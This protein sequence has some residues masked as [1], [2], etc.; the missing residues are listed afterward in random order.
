MT[1][2]DADDVGTILLVEQVVH[3]PYLGVTTPLVG[4]VYWERWSAVPDPHARIAA[5]ASD[6]GILTLW[7]GWCFVSVVIYIRRG[8]RA[9]KG[10]C[11]IAWRLFLGLT[12]KPQWSVTVRQL[13]ASLT[14]KLAHLIVCDLGDCCCQTG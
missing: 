14:Q 11:R 6:I 12:E 7:R 5:S 3:Y 13:D 8:G 2:L 4:E 10:P 1:G 9:S